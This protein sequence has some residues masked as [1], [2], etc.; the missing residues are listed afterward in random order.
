MAIQRIVYEIWF[1]CSKT[2]SPASEK[3]SSNVWWSSQAF[4]ISRWHLFWPYPF[5]WCCVIFTCF[6]YTSVGIKHP[7][8]KYLVLRQ[9]GRLC[10]SKFEKVLSANFYDLDLWWPHM[11]LHLHQRQLELHHQYGQCTYYIRDSPQLRFYSYYEI[12]QGY[13]PSTLCGQSM[14]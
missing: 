7:L 14:Y 9:K 1:S 12:I 13:P 3:I 2:E 8:T 4:W 6:T 11:S 5:S 10:I